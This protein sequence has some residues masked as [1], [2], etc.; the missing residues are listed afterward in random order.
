MRIL[1]KGLGSALAGG[2]L[3]L[4]AG[5]GEKLPL[6]APPVD[7]PPLTVSDTTYIQ[8][9]PVWHGFNQPKDVLVG[10]E[11]LIYVADTGNNRVVMMDIAGNPL[12]ASRPIAHPV[13]L[14]QDSR[15]RLLIV[16]ETNVVYRLDLYAVQ[17]RI[18]HAVV[19]SIFHLNQQ[20]NPQWRF[21]GITAYNR[22]DFYVTVTGPNIKDNLILDFKKSTGWRGAPL[23]LHSGGTGLLGVA[24][25]SGITTPNL[26]ASD[27]LFTQ[28]GEN[29]YKVQ[30]LMERVEV[31]FVSR[32]DPGQGNLDLFTVGK[33]QQPEDITL[34]EER[35]IYVIDAGSDSLFK[36]TGEGFELQSFGGH[37]SGEK[38]FDHPSGVAFFDRTVYVADTGNNRIVRFKLST[39]IGP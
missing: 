15:L 11:P 37:G 35:N 26:F 7:I 24:S 12:G 5:C 33:F 36:F 20:N 2:A 10:R 31:G 39:D 18:S 3:V 8:L 13:A 27:F 29:F 34:D 6:P 16:N 22:E 38:Q 4:W 32:L 30:W 21:T 17:H 19:D 14:S 1:L 28:T 25:P 23:P 9:S